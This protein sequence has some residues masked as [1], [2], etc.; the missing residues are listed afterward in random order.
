MCV[1]SFCPSSLCGSL[2][3]TLL[4]SNANS[5]PEWDAWARSVET[6]DPAVIH[7]AVEPIW[8]LV[9]DS[10]KAAHVQTAALNY[11]TVHGKSWPSADPANYTM[12]WC[13]CETHVRAQASVPPYAASQDCNDVVSVRDFSCPQGKVMTSFELFNH[14]DPGYNYFEGGCAGF[15]CCRPCFTVPQ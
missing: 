15:K 9:R 10:G 1:A 13:D 14:D 11:T 3:P 12:G 6:G 5:T 7:L 4:A 8:T 2:T